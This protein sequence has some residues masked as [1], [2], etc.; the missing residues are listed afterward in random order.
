MIAVP[1]PV[2]LPLIAQLLLPG[3]VSGTPMSID[4]TA[5]GRL[6]I[7]RQ[8]LRPRQVAV[9]VAVERLDHGVGDDRDVE[10][11]GNRQVVGRHRC[12]AR[13]FASG[14]AE[15]RH[16]ARQRQF[17]TRV[18][19]RVAD[20]RTQQ[21]LLGVHGSGPRAGQL[22]LDRQ[23]V[24]G[25]RD[26]RVHAGGI[27]GEDPLALRGDSCSTPRRRRVPELEA[28]GSADRA[29]GRPARP[30][31]RRGL[32]R[33][34]ATSPSATAD[35]ARRRILARRTDRPRSARRCAARPTRRAGLRLRP[36]VRE[37][38]TRPSIARQRRPWPAART[39]CGVTGSAGRAQPLCAKTPAARRFRSNRSVAT[40]P[41]HSSGITQSDPIGNR[42]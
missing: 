34:A 29:A 7:L 24:A 33:C 28:G 41:S 9:H 36:S 40:T 37:R 19:E 10:P 13:R 17:G 42:S 30:A 32:R 22:E 39:S 38:A 26:E 8:N 15:C 23:V 16:A 14:Q 3:E 12:G 27:G 1:V 18:A 11:V 25:R 35:P 5:P 2:S 21:Q 20:A 31:P 4:A 6:A